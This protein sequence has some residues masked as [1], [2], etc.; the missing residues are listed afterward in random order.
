M[1]GNTRIMNL[2]KVCRVLNIDEEH[3]DYWYKGLRKANM[4]R[5]F[6]V[7]DMMVVETTQKEY[8][9]VDNTPEVRDILRG[10]M[11]C[12]SS[13]AQTAMYPMVNPQ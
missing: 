10:H 11:F 9:L 2:N 7:D 5:Y 4:N 6:K 3:A 13:S 8:V 1:G 12:P